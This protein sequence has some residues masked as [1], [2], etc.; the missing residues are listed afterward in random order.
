MKLLTRFPQL[1]THEEWTTPV[2][3]QSLYLLYLDF[4][5]AFYLVPKINFK[6]LGLLG[7]YRERIKELG[8]MMLQNSMQ[9]WISSRACYYIIEMHEDATIERYVI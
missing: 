5:V 1:V 3:K 2:W 6:L 9:I 8:I 7:I 4:S